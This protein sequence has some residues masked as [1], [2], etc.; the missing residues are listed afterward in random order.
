MLFIST[1]DKRTGEEKIFSTHLGD[2]HAYTTLNS[3]RNSQVTEVQ[4]DGDELAICFELLSRT[5]NG[6]LVYSFV[7]DAA[8][9]IVANWVP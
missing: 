9:E 1:E 5:P 2:D 6:R 8:K 4:A 7:G 3:F